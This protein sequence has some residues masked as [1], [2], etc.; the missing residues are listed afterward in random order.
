MPPKA[1]IPFPDKI[2]AENYLYAH[3]FDASGNAI[4][5]HSA[6]LRDHEPWKTALKKFAA[7]IE[8]IPDF[9]DMKA[10]AIREYKL[11]AEK[12][13]LMV[14]EANMAYFEP[15]WQSF[16]ATYKA[17]GKP[18]AVPKPPKAKVALQSKAP[19]KAKKGAKAKPKSK[20]LAKAKKTV[21][22]KPKAKATAQKKKK[23]SV[24]KPAKTQK[25]KKKC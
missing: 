2:A 5:G 24:K 14:A 4:P 11:S 16:I 19:A 10:Q 1:I 9:Q 21:K 15:E 17:A 22:A 3:H 23:K 25:K 6:W 20:K 18:K 8:H 12:A 13:T 7:T